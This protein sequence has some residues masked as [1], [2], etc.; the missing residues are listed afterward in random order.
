MIVPGSRLLFLD[1]VAYIWM[2]YESGPEL[3][4]QGNPG[5]LS[6]PDAIGRRLRTAIAPG[7][8][9]DDGLCGDFKDCDGTLQWCF[10]DMQVIGCWELRCEDSVL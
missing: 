10:G 4:V 9:Y 7:L 8:L 1:A 6:N 3:K 2:K 5:R